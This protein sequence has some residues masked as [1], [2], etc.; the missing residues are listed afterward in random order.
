MNANDVV[1][2]RV[3]DSYN[4]WSD[5]AGYKSQS[6]NQNSGAVLVNGEYFI[7]TDPGKGYGIPVSIS[8]NGILNINS[9]SVNPGDVVY[10][11]VRDNSFR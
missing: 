8:S 3:K 5:P 11:R 1:Y 7:N 2:F 4:R 10:L 6:P 9:L